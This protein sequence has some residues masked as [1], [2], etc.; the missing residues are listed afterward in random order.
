M[1]EAC[2]PMWF[3][4]T[5]AIW[6]S[7]MALVSAA[8]L[9]RS[10]SSLYGQ[11][12]FASAITMDKSGKLLVPSDPIIPFIEGDGTGPDI[13]KASQYVLDG[14]VSKAYGGQK[15]IAWLEVLAGEKA[16]RKTGERS[17]FHW[18]ALVMPCS[19]ELINISPSLLKIFPP[20]SQIPQ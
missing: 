16:F 19:L 11:A 3:P 15:K 18:V 17:S 12:R 8:R 4:V 10:L 6:C 20:S 14:A 7:A 2:Y 5:F 13:W 9:S 1:I